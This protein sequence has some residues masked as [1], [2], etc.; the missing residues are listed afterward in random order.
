MVLVSHIL[1]Q[2]ASTHSKEL[3]LKIGFVIYKFH[4]VLYNE[5]AKQER[6]DDVCLLGS[7]G[8][9]GVCRWV[10]MECS[11]IQIRSHLP[12]WSVPSPGTACRGCMVLDVQQDC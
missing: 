9:G 1:W 6:V 3:R 11:Y 2:A 12:L 4:S 10:C 7:T 8:I 5:A